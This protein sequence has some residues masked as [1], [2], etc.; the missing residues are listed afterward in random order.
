MAIVKLTGGAK[1]AGLAAG[2]SQ[3]LGYELQE[4]KAKEMAEFESNLKMDY[5]KRK[6]ALQ[7]EIDL[8]T[9]ARAHAWDIKRMEASADIDFQ[10]KE[11]RRQ[12]QISFIDNDIDGIDKYMKDN[13]ITEENSE[14]WS[15]MNRKEKLERDRADILAG[16]TLKAEQPSYL[17][18]E[19]QREAALRKVGL[20]QEEKSTFYEKAKAAE[21]IS[22]WGL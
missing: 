18:P 21:I 22:L 15:L 19:E 11:R 12:Q 3:A 5:E 1:E 9:E 10:Y 2:I 8:A 4:K 16:R 14:Y 6:A 17:S 13:N 20:E 7:Y